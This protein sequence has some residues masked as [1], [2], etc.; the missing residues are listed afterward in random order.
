M[1]RGQQSELEISCSIASTLLKLLGPEDVRTLQDDELCHNVY[2]T[3]SMAV[4][5]PET[6]LNHYLED[7]TLE[8]DTA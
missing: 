4:A 2:G 5:Y 7:K 6:W 3:L 1:C 8:A